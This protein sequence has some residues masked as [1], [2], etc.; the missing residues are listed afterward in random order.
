MAIDP[1]R[2]EAIFFAALEIQTP[3]AHADASTA[4]T[5]PTAVPKATTEGKPTARG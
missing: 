3:E 1:A 5:V 4:P 2:V